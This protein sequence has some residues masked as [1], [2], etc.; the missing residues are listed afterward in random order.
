MDV[1]RRVESGLKPEISKNAGDPGESRGGLPE[2]RLAATRKAIGYLA[3]REHSSLEIRQKLK[4]AGCQEHL[5][6][7]IV[8]ELEQQ[9]LLSDQ[10]FAEAYVRYRKLKGFGPV[11]I[12]L[13]MEQ[14]GV[15][16]LLCAE[17]IE[18]NGGDWFDHAEKIRVKKFGIDPPVDYKERARQARF[19][20][21]RGF[22]SDQIQH[23]L[24]SD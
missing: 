21:H 8:T 10:R 5:T 16:S 4:N 3:R 7:E 12:R 13:E 17:A 23:A 24:S 1:S 2:D 11:R 20:Q 19:L 6:A 15:S 18:Q 14:K 22:S 9:G